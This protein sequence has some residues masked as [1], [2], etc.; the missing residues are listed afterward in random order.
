MRLRNVGG[1]TKFQG[2]GADVRA[3]EGVI[4][5]LRVALSRA[6]AENKRL[7]RELA[8]YRE[9][10]T[11]LEDVAADAAT[12]TAVAVVSLEKRC[13]EALRTLREEY[14]SSARNLQ[15]SL[16][17]LAITTEAGNC[18]RPRRNVARGHHAELEMI[19]GANQRDRRVQTPHNSSE[20]YQ[21][22]ATS[23]ETPQTPQP[24]EFAGFGGATDD[25]LGAGTPRC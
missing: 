7:S 2:A 1:R 15:S 22:V 17:V 8:E 20:C 6:T 14:E 25:P 3:L 23:S 4:Q 18:D 21:V 16:E 10:C 12:S 13:R 5:N 9:R 11:I 19:K 24:M